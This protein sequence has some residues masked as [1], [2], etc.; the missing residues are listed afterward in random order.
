ME[1]S[2]GVDVSERTS[3]SGEGNERLGDCI[4]EE[5]ESL[6]VDIDERLTISRMVSDSVIKGMINAVEQEAAEKISQ[7]EMELVGLKEKLHSYHVGADATINHHVSD[8]IVNHNGPLESVESIQLVVNGLLKQL[9]KENDKIGGNNSFRRISSGS[10]LVGLSGILHEEVPERWIYVDRAIENLAATLETFYQKIEVITQSS[11]AS[12]SEWQQEQEFRSEIEEM[13]ISNCI[14]S[15]QGEFEQT[16]CDQNAQICNFENGNWFHKLEEISGLRQ[17]LEV[18]SKALSVSETGLLL[19]HG[20][21]ENGDECCDHKIGGHFHRKLSTNQQSHSIGDENGK[22]ED[23]NKPDNLDSALLNH[24]SADELISHYDSKISEMKRNH[25]SEVQEI[26]EENIRLR[27]QLYKERGSSLPLKKDKELE[28][29][30]KKIPDFITKLDAVFVGNEK[31][32]PL[33]EKIESVNS[34]KARLELLHTENH[35]L[36]DTLG[37]KKEEIRCL[38]S[39]LSDA[40]E[41][42]S[43]EQ[44][45]QKDLV[46]TIRK[47]EGDMGEAHAEVAVIQDVYRSVL[48]EI[49]SEFRS[50]AEESHLKQTIMEEVLEVVFK[51]AAHDAQ[52]SSR[53]EF[54]DE[55]MESIIMQELLDLIFKEAL[56]DANKESQEYE[57][58]EMRKLEQEILR[59]TSIVEEKTLLAQEAAEALTYEKKNLEL[60]SEELNSLRAKTIDQQ[61]VISESNKELEVTKAELVKAL[62]KVEEYEEQMHDLRQNLEQRTKELREIDEQRKLL[63]SASKEQQ[64]A[65]TLAAEKER[66]TRKQMESAIVVAHNLLTAFAKFESRVNED[67]SRNSLRIGNLNSEFQFLNDKVSMLKTMGLLYKQRLEMRCSDLQKAEAEVD[68]LGNDVDALVSLLE[69]VYIALDHYSP[70]LRHYPGVIEILELVRRELSG[71]SKKPV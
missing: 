1:G 40:V 26:T 24:M 8:T 63:W 13:V 66:E 17:E 46:H 55:E 7:T 22:H 64:H 62:K 41:K 27:G 50:I 65:L 3:D 15:L 25:E 6:L 33:S 34:L 37:D 12:L 52:P 9:K 32:H 44:L 19:S 56:L 49:T 58:A 69:K 43:Q 5:M 2:T 38:S 57:T 36:Q 70:I 14:R 45:T 61:N 4:V 53:L 59:L 18:L 29:L 31:L 67:I 48:E 11:K 21:L 60:A 51:E 23:S 16:L 10:Q 28:M 68:L 42:L 30:R 35:Q 54:E 71:E 20:S 47:L 39:Q